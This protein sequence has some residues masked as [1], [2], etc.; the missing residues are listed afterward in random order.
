MKN[1]IPP[2]NPCVVFATQKNP[3]VFHRPKKIPFGQNVRPKKLFWTPPSLKYV[4]GAPGTKLWLSLSVNYSRNP[5][6]GPP[7]VYQDLS[8]HNDC[9]V[10]KAIIVFAI[11]MKGNSKCTSGNWLSPLRAQN[12]DIGTALQRL[13]TKV[14]LLLRIVVVPPES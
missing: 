4:S 14:K 7:A 13:L 11:K 10:K 9:F 2:K 1:T 3:G 6:S 12:K 5:C 8:M